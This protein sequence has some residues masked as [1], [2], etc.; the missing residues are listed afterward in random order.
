[1]RECNHQAKEKAEVQVDL[2]NCKTTDSEIL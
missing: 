1:M 2:R